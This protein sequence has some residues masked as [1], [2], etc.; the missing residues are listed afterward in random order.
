M[1]EDRDSGTT[2]AHSFLSASASAILRRL[3]SDSRMNQPEFLPQC[4]CIDIRCRYIGAVLEGVSTETAWRPG[5]CAPIK[6]RALDLA[7]IAGK[8][9]V[10]NREEFDPNLLLSQIV[11]DYQFLI[12]NKNV[13]LVKLTETSV[14]INADKDRIT[15]VVYNLIDNAIKFTKIGKILVSAEIEGDHVIVKVSDSGPSIDPNLFPVLFSKFVTMSEKGTGLGLYISKNIVEAH[16]GTMWAKNNDNGQ[17]LHSPL[18]YRCNTI[19]L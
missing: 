13:K 15:E 17:G 2:F 8:L 14:R 11:S 16:G 4:F 5:V 9:L 12:E 6:W 7:R 1:P 3:L 10:I 19:L 18:I